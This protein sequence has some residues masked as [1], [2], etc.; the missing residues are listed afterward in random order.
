LPLNGPSSLSAVIVPV[1]NTSFPGGS[2]LNIVNTIGPF[3]PGLPKVYDL[4]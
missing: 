1:S 2:Y 3:S 4:L